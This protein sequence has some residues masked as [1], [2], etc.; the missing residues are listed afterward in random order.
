[1]NWC[2]ENKSNDMFSHR[3]RVA[4]IESKSSH[5]MAKALVDYAQ[6]HSIKPHTDAVTEFHNFPGEG[7]HGKLDS[8]NIYIG[9]RRIAQRAHS[10]HGNA[11][12][13]IEVDASGGKTRGYIY[14]NGTLS[15]WFSLSDTCRSG[16]L[17]AV[18]ELKSM[19][20]LTV[21][22]TGDS[23]AAAAQAQNQVT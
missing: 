21:M 14:C 3:C 22:L 1:M 11:A 2:H 20:I 23:H 16:T 10:D 9:N 19:N 5:P 6:L 17:Q 8:Q 13:E 18:N 4:S 12:S 15:G 7:I